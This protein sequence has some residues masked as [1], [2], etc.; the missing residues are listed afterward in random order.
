MMKFQV[1]ISDVCVC[2]LQSSY[3]GLTHDDRRKLRLP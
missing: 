2:V 3:E 1:R